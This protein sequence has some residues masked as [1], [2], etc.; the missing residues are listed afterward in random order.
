VHRILE[1]VD[2]KMSAR[3]VVNEENGTVLFGIERIVP[4]A[5]L[6]MFSCSIPEYSIWLQME[7]LKSQGDMVAVTYLLRERSTGEVAAYMSLVADAIKL[8]AAEKALHNLDYPF[9]TIP[10]MKIAKLAVS[11][12]Y[13][14]RYPA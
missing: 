3:I 5:R 11:T 9:K 14:Q 6:D 2:G 4:P 8:N 13:Q 7:S 1:S 12:A 10:A